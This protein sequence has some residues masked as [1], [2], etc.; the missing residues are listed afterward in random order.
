MKVHERQDVY[1]KSFAFFRVAKQNC[2][3]RMLS[4]G[5]LSFYLVLASICWLRLDRKKILFTFLP[6]S[7]KFFFKE[8]LKVFA[9]QTLWIHLLVNLG[10]YIKLR[11]CIGIWL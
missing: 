1:M 10:T 9:S 6:L 8:I 7:K 4:L 3:L 11:V 2:E 5:D